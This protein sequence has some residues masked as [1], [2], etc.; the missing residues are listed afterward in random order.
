M[1]SRQQTMADYFHCMY[2][3]L[4]VPTVF[5][6][7]LCPDLKYCLCAIGRHTRICMEPE[8]FQRICVVSIFMF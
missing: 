3:N 5:E 8:V 4:P 1:T 6:Y 2:K 7:G